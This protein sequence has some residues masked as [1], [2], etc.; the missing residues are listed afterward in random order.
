GLDVTPVE[1]VR[2]QSNLDTLA[3]AQ[4]QIALFEET[5]TTLAAQDERVLL[6]IQL[7]GMGLITAMTLLAAMGDISRFPTAKKLVGYS[8]RGLEGYPLKPSSLFLRA[9]PVGNAPYWEKGEGTMGRYPP[10]PPTC[11]AAPKARTKKE[12]MDKSNGQ[13]MSGMMSSF[14]TGSWL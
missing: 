7:P 2:I 9:E 10:R 4:S 11:C 13:P 3:F 5:L 6:L 12:Y 14:H 1:R 8:G